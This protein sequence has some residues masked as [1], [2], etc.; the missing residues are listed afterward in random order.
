MAVLPSHA[1][2]MTMEIL[3]EPIL[4]TS[5]GNRDKAEAMRR[6]CHRAVTMPRGS[7]IGL[8]MSTRWHRDLVPASALSFDGGSKG[9][10][11]LRRRCETLPRAASGR[12][13]RDRPPTGADQVQPSPSQMF[14]RV[15]GA[16]SSRLADS[17]R[18][19]MSPCWAIGRRPASARSA[20]SCCRRRC[21]SLSATQSNSSVRAVGGEWYCVPV[22]VGGLP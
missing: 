2:T 18:A 15:R 4:Q 19:Q 1:I 20:K 12:S 17:S 10:P 16:A 13:G 6:H 11:D 14:R 3:T 21:A 5:V 7:D 9:T 22:R 8:S